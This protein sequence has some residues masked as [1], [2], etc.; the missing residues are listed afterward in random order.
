M[1]PRHFLNIQSQHNWMADRAS[2]FLLLNISE[3]KR[4]TTATLCKGDY[5]VTFVSGCGFA[6]VR[7]VTGTRPTLAKKSSTN[8]ET[9]SHALETIPVAA[10]HPDHH[11]PA[12]LLANR[13]GITCKDAT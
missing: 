1:T 5:I 13:L 8:N 6:D 7:Y 2:G 10:I 11:F 3:R 12:A 4:P 9:A